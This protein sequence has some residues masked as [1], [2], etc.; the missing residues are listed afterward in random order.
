MH[1][2]L[3]LATAR[4]A[5]VRTSSVFAEFKSCRTTV[6]HNLGCESDVM[7]R[8]RA[9]FRNEGDTKISSFSL[10][11]RNRALCIFIHLKCAVS[12]R[13]VLLEG[14]LVDG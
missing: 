14:F 5:M 1:T 10:I 8:H 6:R 13:V 9:L 4:G 2:D 11:A 7:N 3:L 12:E